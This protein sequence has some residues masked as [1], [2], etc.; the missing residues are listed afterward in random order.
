MG[1]G[2]LIPNKSLNKSE[3]VAYITFF[4]ANN[5][6]IHLRKR[7]TI[8]LTQQQQLLQQRGEEQNDIV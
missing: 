1:N 6:K 5:V 7:I 3:I 4:A 8:I 2:I